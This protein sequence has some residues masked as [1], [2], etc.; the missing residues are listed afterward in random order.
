MNAMLVR[1]KGMVLCQS[2]RG[3]CERRYYDQGIVNIGA[4]NDN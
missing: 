4:I 3:F 2:G 1:R